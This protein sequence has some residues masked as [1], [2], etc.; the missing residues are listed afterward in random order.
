MAHVCCTGM[1]PDGALGNLNTVT[2]PNAMEVDPGVT[3]GS[4]NGMVAKEKTQQR[5]TETGTE[6]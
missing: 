2:V 5:N 1:T 4:G 6:E 3:H